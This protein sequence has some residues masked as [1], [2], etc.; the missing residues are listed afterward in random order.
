MIRGYLEGHLNIVKFGC[1]E[2]LNEECYTS[3]AVPPGWQA[4][5]MLI[6]LKKN[7]NEVCQ[8]CLSHVNVLK[9]VCSMARDSVGQNG[10]GQFSDVCG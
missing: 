10:I 5:S 8:Q 3:A 9:L 2:S 4:I 1:C 6:V 7:T